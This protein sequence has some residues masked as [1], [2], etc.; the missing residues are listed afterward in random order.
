MARA[1][2]IKPAF[3]HNDALSELEPLTRLLFIGLWGIADREGRIEFRPKKIKAEVLPYDN[4]DI[5]AM[6]LSL[7][8][9][10][11]ILIY[12]MNNCYYIQVLNFLK[13]QKPHTK[14][15]PSYIPAP[16]KEMLNHNL[17]NAQPQ[18]RF[19][20]VL[21]LTLNPLPLTLNPLPTEEQN[22][23]QEITTE[24]DRRDS[25]PNPEEHPRETPAASIREPETP[26]AEPWQ[27]IAL[28]M[29]FN[30]FWDL[31]PN[32]SNL[33]KC[34]DEFFNFVYLGTPAD[35]IIDGMRRYR[36]YIDAGLEEPMFVKGS[37]NWLKDRH[38]TNAYILKKSEPEKPKRL[39]GL[40]V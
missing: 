38:W 14:E 17:G 40:V 31:C 12:E 15:L 35:K 13:H 11:F 22:H 28:M 27:D 29:K 20:P 8:Q 7:N 24:T 6:L 36:A 23:D 10:G 1:R 19:V 3:F 5:D 30:E 25:Q 33:S 21:P 32:K 16:T 2:I 9:H 34:R 37:L 39:R 26:K 18:P 4:C